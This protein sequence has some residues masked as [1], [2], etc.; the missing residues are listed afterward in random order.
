M[1]ASGG[2]GP[3]QNVAIA[4]RST[5]QQLLNSVPALVVIRDTPRMPFDP[6][7]CLAA[8]GSCEAPI[9]AAMTDSDPIVLAA[10]SAKAGLQLLD[11]TRFFCNEELCYSLADNVLMWRDYHHV[12]ATYSRLLAVQ[13]AELPAIKRLT[14]TSRQ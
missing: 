12:T 2:A 10:T 11:M 9:S 6:P 7:E 14:S 3:H 4:L 5:W 1:Q 13:F 8:G